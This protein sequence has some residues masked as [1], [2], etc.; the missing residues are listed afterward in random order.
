MAS[1]R[2]T[3]T[4]ESVNTYGDATRNYTVLA[5]W[6][7]DTDINLVTGTISYVLECYDDAA[8]F[9]DYVTIAGA[10]TSSSY[11]RIIRPAA[12]QGHDGT[13]NNGVYFN[14]TSAQHI[15]LINEAN[16]QVQDIIAT[17]SVNSATSFVCFGSSAT[18]GGVFVGCIAFDSTNIGTGV[19]R[20]F[21]IGN[22]ANVKFIN[23]FAHNNSSHGFLTSAGV[24]GGNTFYYNCI[25]TN[26]GGNGFLFQSTA[27]TYSLKNCLSIGNL[28]TAFVNSST[29]T[30]DVDYCASDDLSADDW[31][32]TGNITSASVT[33]ANSA[34]NDFHLASTDTDVIDDGTDLSAD[35]TYPF[36]DDIDKT[37]RTGSWDIGF[38]EYVAAGG[39]VSGGKVKNII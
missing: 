3:G 36:D 31:G 22:V 27:N 39:W 21:G 26:N 38:D 16:S 28:L 19:A 7:A 23:C 14:S 4:N 11:F 33:F 32:G 37:T 20:G 1:S 15:F 12:G 30:M 8:S 6:E 2:R 9:N 13:P 17:L 35:A 24:A 5:T 34:G 10:T 18:G 29:G 25:S